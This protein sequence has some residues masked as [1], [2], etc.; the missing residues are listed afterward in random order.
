MRLLGTQRD[1]SSFQTVV[2]KH[3][4]SGKGMVVKT[5]VVVFQPG[6]R[7][8]KADI[9]VLST[10]FQLARNGIGTLSLQHSVENYTPGQGV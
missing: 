3:R 7:L 9:S 5:V 6:N 8:M 4:L 10:D 1:R 2:C